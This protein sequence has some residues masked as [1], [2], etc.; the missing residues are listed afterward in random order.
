M[1][2]TE[3]FMTRQEAASIFGVTVQTIANWV[4]KGLLAGGTIAKSVLVNKESVNMLVR[5]YS[6]IQKVEMQ[7]NQYQS[8]LNKRR[9]E[10]KREH[11]ECLKAIDIYQLSNQ[12]KGFL[13][14]MIYESYKALSYTRS[15]R[16]IDIT[17]K[18]FWGYNLKEI[19]EEYGVGAERIRQIIEESLRSLSRATRYDSLLQNIAELEKSNS[20]LQAEIEMLKNEFIRF[21]EDTSSNFISK[22]EDIFN[23]ELVDTKLPTGALTRLHVKNIYTLGELVQYKKREI[24]N[25]NHLGPKAMKAIEDLLLSKGLTWEM[26]IIPEK[27]E[28]EEYI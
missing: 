21:R 4:E 5:E 1:M 14:K 9:N 13:M 15:E 18:F 11:N 7:I 25:I 28:E 20:A 23:I 10:L 19:G 27:E 12:K 8:E 22:K 17:L 26:K 6:N 24:S 16:E 3:K 2:D